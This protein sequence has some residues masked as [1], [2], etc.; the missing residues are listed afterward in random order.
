MQWWDVA[1]GHLLEGVNAHATSVRAIVFSP[2]GLTMASG[3]EDQTVRLWNVPTRRQLMQLDHGS[4]ELGTV[5]TLHFSP[6]GK[7]LFAGGLGSTVIWTTAPIGWNDPE[8]FAEKLRLLLNSNADFKSR[9]RMFSENLR[10]HEALGELDTEDVRVKAALAAAQANWHASRREWAAAVAA[11]DRLVAV[12]PTDHEDWLRTPGL[13]RV[14]TALVQQDRPAQAAILLQGG[15]K[16]RA[17]DGLPA[18]V[19]DGTLGFLSSAAD[20]G[21]RVS[22]LLPGSPAARSPLV[23]GDVIVKVND[24][25]LKEVSASRL[26]ELLAGQAGTKVK[27]WVRHSGSEKPEVIELTRARF[28]NDPATGDQLHPLR[29]AVDLRLAKEPGDAGLLELRAELAGQWS[30]AKAQ[31]ADYTAAIEALAQQKPEPVAADLKRLYGRRGNSYVALRH[32]QP[33]LGDYAR[34][35]TAAT[36]D[37]TLLSNQALALAETMLTRALSS[38]LA[39]VNQERKH[40]AVTKLT[41]PWQKLAAAYQLKGDQKAIDQLVERRPKSAGPIGDLFTQGKDQDKDWRRAIDLYSKGISAKA[42]DALLLAKRARAYE[43]LKNW[44]AAAGDWARAATLNPD[45]AKL[46]AEFARRLVADGQVSLANG[47]FEKSRVLYERSLEM[48]PENDLVATELAQ[49]LLDQQES[50]NATRWTVLKPVEAKSELGAILSMLPDDSI[51]ASGAN[52]HK[53]RYRVVLTVGK[54][55]DLRAVRLEALAHPSLPGNGPGRQAAGTFAQISWIVTARSRDRKKT[56]SLQF[57]KAWADYQLEGYPIK[58][59]GH[60]NISGGHGGNRTAIWSMSNP[61][62]LATGT[63]LTFEM[64]CQTGFDRAENLGHFRLSVTSDPAALD[65]RRNHSPEWSSPIPGPGLPR[66]ISSSAISRRSTA[67]S[68][69]TRQ[70]LPP[71][72]IG[73][74]PLRIGSG[75]SSNIASWLP[76]SRLTAPCLRDSPRSTSRPAARARRWRIWRRYPPPIRR[77]TCFR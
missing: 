22:E 8:R 38:D 5:Q 40:L 35:V 2:D 41:D 34:V 36:T 23:P 69:I 32:W 15:A 19:N 17:E 44:E 14:A 59:D 71:S 31:A 26:S 68:N 9:V 70:W 30:D 28:I 27:L 53:D 3:S 12:D 75:P 16:R 76:P 67:W 74:R 77:T 46:L 25:E 21:V 58:T 37:D 72:A 29:S 55:I 64:Q 24:V 63:T 1:T 57:D 50:E 43:A 7:H 13:L 42:T 65:R 60:W 11:F 62:S 4:L 33:A 48:A 54:N 18:V 6:D 47:P 10:L 66:H 51:L 39:A 73:T 20:G 45:G 52:A 49:L 61:V 56:I